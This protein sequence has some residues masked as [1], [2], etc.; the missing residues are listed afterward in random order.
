MQSIK[1]ERCIVM[2]KSHLILG[3]ISQI[4]LIESKFPIAGN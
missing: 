2:W 4:H 3:E 1:R